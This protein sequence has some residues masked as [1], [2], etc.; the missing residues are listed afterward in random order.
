MQSVAS[1]KA[2]GQD[3]PWCVEGTGRRPM[4][5]EQS[6]RG[7]REE[8]REGRIQKQVVQG[9]VGH[10]EDVGFYPQGGGNPRGLWAEEGGV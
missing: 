9:F 1:E 5:L 7:E 2:L 6:E 8:V 10:G 3:C 4:W